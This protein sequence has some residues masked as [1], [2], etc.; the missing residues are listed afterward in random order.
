MKHDA[1]SAGKS[2][3]Q[4]LKLESYAAKSQRNAGEFVTIFQKGGGVKLLRSSALLPAGMIVSKTSF[5][6]NE[7]VETFY[8]QYGYGPSPIAGRFAIQKYNGSDITFFGWQLAAPTGGGPDQLLKFNLFMGE[9]K[10]LLPSPPLGFA[11]LAVHVTYTPPGGQGLSVL[12][13]LSIS[14]NGAE[15]IHQF[16]G[17]GTDTVFLLVFKP[18]AITQVPITLKYRKDQNAGN[19]SIV[20]NKVERFTS[21]L[22][23]LEDLEIL[24]A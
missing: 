4:K 10:G 14:V 20:I 6:A 17:D 23:P 12:P 22:F 24:E 19:T 5:L 21:F 11:I 7:L 2:D 18:E 1:K 15:T 8:P 13:H 16:L 9:W 3:T